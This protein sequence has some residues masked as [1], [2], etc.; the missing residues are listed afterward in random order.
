ME[1]EVRDTI[2]DVR[3]WVSLLQA[4]AD[5]GQQA[6]VVLDPDRRVLAFNRLAQQFAESYYQPLAT[7]HLYD[8]TLRPEDRDDIVSYI[9]RALDGAMVVTERKLPH[10]EGH[11]WVEIHFTPL[12][13]AA[14]AV[15]AICL[16]MLSIDDRKRAEEKLRSAR[17]QLQAILANIADGVA[18]LMPDGRIRYANEA[19]AQLFGYP[20]A[21]ELIG[22]ELLAVYERLQMRDEN[23]GP[24][25]PEAMPVWQVFQGVPATEATYCFQPLGSSEDRWVVVRARPVPDDHGNV[26]FVVKSFHDITRLRRAEEGLQLLVEAGA[27]LGSALEYESTILQVAELVTSRMADWCAID[28]V[29]EDGGVARVA[30]VH[31]DPGSW[32]AELEAQLSSESGSPDLIANVLRS[33][34]S[35]LYT[36]IP[37]ERLIGR[38]HA[39]N[40]VAFW[41]DVGP[42]SIIAAPLIRRER[43]IGAITLISAT[44]CRRYTQADLAVIEE[45]AR[46]IAQAV[47]NARLYREARRAAEE[48]RRQAARVQMLAEASRI[49]AEASL[50][51][52]AV[53]HAVGRFIGE[54]LGELCIIRLLSDDGRW[55]EPAMVYHPD[56][57]VQRALRDVV[58]MTPLRAD[59]G[60][61]GKVVQ[62]GEALLIP[63]LAALPPEKRRSLMPSYELVREYFDARSLLAAPL[64]EQGQ[65]IGAVCL[66]RN[67]PR[68]PYTMDDQ[69][70]LQELAD[71]AALAIANARLYER[72][73]QRERRVLGS[74]ASTSGERHAAVIPEPLSKRERE[75]LRYLAQGLTNREIADTLH[76]SQ[77]TVKAHV[78]SIIGKLGVANRTQ[79]VVRALELGLLVSP[80]E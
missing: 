7:G 19:L 79:A 5:A 51:F 60:I 41:D 36:E 12:R 29:T 71:R 2:A 77:G 75:V 64:R 55:L 14:G 62:S 49:F 59:Q 44:A 30:A 66:A 21:G 28:L 31:A 23:G 69:L 3:Q 78:E 58:A 25:S 8:E 18:V 72:I 45:L 56:S 63:D 53:L 22:L 54:R 47:E 76:V 68:R 42:L 48:A 37:G 4:I 17:D 9:Q 27:I 65:V 61:S 52:R 11:I 20:S 43:V 15:Q 40:M 74:F 6:M 24:L 33:G 57:A 10:G 26:R 16:T 67:D 13:N 34:Q 46:T 32:T 35:E 38:K 1:A 39:R 80:L 70:L 73:M 50:D